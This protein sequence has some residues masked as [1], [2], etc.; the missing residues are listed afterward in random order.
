M[1]YSEATILPVPACP[2]TLALRFHG[3]KISRLPPKY[4]SRYRYQINMPEFPGVFQTIELGT[5]YQ[6]RVTAVATHRLVQLIAEFEAGRTLQ[7]PVEGV[8]LFAAGGAIV[9][10]N[11]NDNHSIDMD[12]GHCLYIVSGSRCPRAGFVRQPSSPSPAVGVR[13]ILRRLHQLADPLRPLLSRKMAS[14]KQMLGI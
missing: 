14:R 4:G 2:Q 8:L 7:S 6:S 13:S 12:P 5:E 3:D 10:L 1:C 11:T 9:S